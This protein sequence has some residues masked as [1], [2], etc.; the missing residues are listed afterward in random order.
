MAADILMPWRLI[1]R[2]IT[3]GIATVPDLAAK[4]NVSNSAMSIRLGIPD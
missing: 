1:D 2:A 4:F 3:N